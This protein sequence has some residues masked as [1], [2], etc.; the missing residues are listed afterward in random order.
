MTLRRMPMVAFLMCAAVA[1][2]TG[3]TQAMPAADAALPPN[4][5]A[6]VPI[7][8]GQIDAAV[9][10]LDTLA[11]AMMQ[12]TGL[13][14]MSVAVVHDGREVFAK[15][16]GV[17]NT[18]QAGEVDA[19]TVFQLAS[20]S[21]SVG[22]TVVAHEVGK[23]GVAWNDPVVKYLPGFQLADPWVTAHVTLADFYSHRS[24]LPDHAGDDLE[25]LGYD[26]GQVLERLRH[27]PLQAFRS[28][29]AYTNFGVTVAAE[30]VARAAG[31]DWASLSEGV[32]YRPL[33]MDRTS[34]RFADFAADSNHAHGHVKSG[35]VYQPKYQ[36]EPDAQSPAGGVSSSA[37]DM[38]K[39]LAMLL[40]DG[41]DAQGQPLIPAAALLP[42]I[43]PQVI[44][45][46]SSSPTVRADMYGYGFNV[47][48]QSS[49]RT[50]IS[51]SGA[52][53]LGAG[54]AFSIIPSAKVGIVVLTNAAPIG[55]A[56]ALSAEF[57]ELAQFGRITRD[58]YAGYHALFAAY[59][60]PA[61]SLAGKQPPD[62]PAPA[63]Q[64]GA[65]AGDYG[66]AYFGTAH[67]VADDAGLALVLGP[68][69][70]RFPMRHWDGDRFVIAMH[71]ENHEEGSVSAVDFS[72]AG[73]DGMASMRVELLDT[74]HL[75]TF[76][77]H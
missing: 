70:T 30:A 75:G 68:R 16:Y 36:R 62:D 60:E 29:C 15:G 71:D 64:P 77:R 69:N 51:H 8:A 55:A 73:S 47:N 35:G 19:D 67:V 2:A 74:N 45:R 31:R 58:W 6:G 20:L 28:T 32:L 33:H 12:R 25:D 50:G 48:V 37:N 5:T 21:K 9:G 59:A 46:A 52:F 26:R 49:G 43:T 56:E 53:A 54:T 57:M 38:A 17:R 41:H 13:P 27:L 76:Q 22:A 63:R 72:G 3:D 24:G 65:Y 1:A 7:H 14:G 39:W 66:N 34:S 23:Q 40:D 10:Q 42:A 4:E 18:D 44:S 61:G 11:Q